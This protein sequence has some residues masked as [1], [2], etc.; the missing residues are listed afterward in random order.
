MSL[1][2]AAAVAYVLAGQLA[3]VNVASLIR[4]ADW[5]WTGVALVLSALTDAM[6]ATSLTGFVLE[7]LRFIRTLLAQL[8]ASF[9]TLVTPAA[10]GGAALNVRDEHGAGSHR[11]TAQTARVIQITGDDI[12]PLASQPRSRRRRR[13]AGQR[14]DAVPT[15]DQAPGQ[16]P[17]CRLADVTPFPSRIPYP[18]RV[19][20][21]GGPDRHPGNGHDDTGY[22]YWLVTR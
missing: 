21:T 16:H 15:P 4:Y 1:V 2:V 12:G 8:A 5:R 22:P 6:A 13:G 19:I 20:S 14:P 3:Q 18:S 9:V 7:R 11:G 10:V 17:S